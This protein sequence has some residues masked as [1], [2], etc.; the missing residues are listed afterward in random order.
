MF[1]NVLASVKVTINP[2]KFAL[3]VVADLAAMTGFWILFT[4][5]LKISE[6]LAG[7]GAAA[8]ATVGVVV[9]QGQDF[10]RFSPKPQW[11][12]YTLTLPWDVLRDT[13]IVFRAGLKYA[14]RRKSDGYLVS[15]DFNAGGDDQR[16]SARRALVTALTTIPP[17]SIVLGIDKKENRILLHLLA[18]TEIPGIIRKLGAPQ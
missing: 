11:L 14:L 4:S 13:A 2:A 12:L 6:L 8:I 9:V 18:P 17:N 7:L 10:A 1:P 15:V 3:F 16:S 5:T